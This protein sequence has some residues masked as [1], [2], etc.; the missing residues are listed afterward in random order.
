MVLKNSIDGI[1]LFPRLR[2][3]SS[4]RDAKLQVGHPSKAAK[5]NLVSA[6]TWTIKVNATNCQLRAADEALNNT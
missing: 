3:Q 1:D 5:T 6:Q 4:S 2:V